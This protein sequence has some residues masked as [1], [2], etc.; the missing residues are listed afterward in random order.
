M[1]NSVRPHGL[2]PARLLCPWISQAR[3]LEWVAITFPGDLPN[4]GIESRSPAL[5]M[6]SLPS[7]PPGKPPNWC[8]FLFKYLEENTSEVNCAQRLPHVNV[9]NYGLDLLNIELVRFQKFS[10]CFHLCK[11]WFPRK[12]LISPTYEN[13]LK[14]I[15]FKCLLDL[16]QFLLHS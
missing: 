7:E 3:I 12:I 4:P 1:S 13:L 8:C 16:W 11:S 5:Q 15:S 9:G 10:S 2:Q 14:Y 6:H